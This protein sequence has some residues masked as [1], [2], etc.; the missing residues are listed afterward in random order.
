[1]SSQVGTAIPASR[2]TALSSSAVGLT[3]SIQTALS[4]SAARSFSAIFFSEDSARTY[5]DNMGAPELGRRLTQQDL[6]RFWQALDDAPVHRRS[7]FVAAEW[8]WRGADSAAAPLC[9]KMSPKPESLRQKGHSQPPAARDKH[10]SSG[11]M[12][13]FDDN[14]LNGIV[15]FGAQCF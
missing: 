15:A 2:S 14:G 11:I 9:P 8:L 7:I 6:A 5:T 4:G 10:L 13:D 3:R 1:M 12:T